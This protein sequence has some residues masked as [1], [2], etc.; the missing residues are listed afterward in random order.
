MKYFNLL[1]IAPTALALMLGISAKAQLV[2]CNGFLQGKYIEVGINSLGSYGSSTAAPAG[3]HPRGSSSVYNT[4]TGTSGPANSSLGFV[5]DPD[6]DG[7]GVGTPN[8]IGDYFLPGSPYEGWMIEVNGSKADANNGASSS[9]G[10][11]TSVTN[12]GATRSA[13]WVGAYAGLSIKQTTSFDTGNLFFTTKVVLKNTT[14]GTLTNVYYLRGVD[15]DQEQPVTGNFATNNTIAYQLPNTLNATLV[16][17]VGQTHGAYLGLGT[18]D[19]RAK[20]YILPSWPPSPALSSVYAGAS[21]FTYAGSNNGDYA[22]GIIFRLGNIVAGDSVTLIYTYI[23][24]G[25]DFLTALLATT[26]NWTASGDATL[27]HSTADTAKVCQSS[28]TTVTISNPGTSTW[29]WSALTGETLSATTGASVTVTTA[30]TIIKLRAVGVSTSSVDTM[31]MYLNPINTVPS[32]PTAGSNSP[33]CQNTALNLTA[34]SGGGTV[35][36]YSWSGPSGFS[37]TVQNPTISSATSGVAG[38]YMVYA[39]N[40]ACFSATGANTTVSVS[41]LAAI[42]GA[43]SLVVSNTTTLTDATGGGTWSSSNNAVATVTSGGLVT[44][45]AI[46]SV[47]ISY[48]HGSCTATKTIAII[49]VPYC[50]ALYSQASSAC[51]VYNMFIN[52]FSFTGAG[53]STLSDIGS[54]CDGT[55]YQDRRGIVGIP[56]VLPGGSY[57]TAIVVGTTYN[58]N[59][60]AWV[61]FNNNGTFETSESIGGASIIG[62]STFTI[63]IPSG[64]ALGTH[65]MRVRVGYSGSTPTYPGLNACSDYSYGEAQDYFIN[66]VSAC[67][68]PTIT[69]AG[70]ITQS[71]ATGACSATVSYSAATATGTTPTITYNHSSGTTFSVGVTTVTATATNSCGTANCSFTVTV[72]DTQAP[73]I[74][75]SYVSATNDAGTCGASVTLSAT[76]TDNCSVGTPSNDWTGGAFPVGTTTVNWTVTDI[77]GNTGTATQTVTV[78]DNQAPVISVTNVSATNDA[79]TCGAS[80]TLSATA[81]DN[82]SVG[83]PSNDWTGGAFPVGTTT[84][85]WTVTDIHGNTSTATQTVTVTDNENP[86]IAAPSSITANNTTGACGTTVSL[87]SPITADN[88]GVASVTNNHSSSTYPVGTTTVIWTVTDVHGHTATATQTVTVIDNEAPYAICQNYTLNLSGGTGSI[89]ATNINNG[90]YDNCGIASMSVYPNSF[91]CSNAGSNTVTLTVKD[92]HGNI[93]TCTATVTVRYQPTCS[94][95]VTKSDTTF[96]GGIVNNI[97]FGYGA[98]A[99]TFT[100]TASGGSGFTYSWYPSTYLSSASVA[101]PTFTPTV[102]G[103]YTYTLTATNSNGCSTTCTVSMCVVDAVDHSH[104]KKVILCHIPPG[105]PGNPNELSISISAVPAH[106]SGHTGDHLGACYSG[107]GIGAKQNKIAVADANLRVYPNP[108]NGSFSVVIPATESEAIVQVTDMTGRVLATRNIADNHGDAIEFNLTNLATGIYFVKVKAGAL[109]FVEKLTVR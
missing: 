38:V 101:N 57:T 103:H 68:V 98:Q 84:V 2:S 48:S 100:G 53:G 74:S 21:G 60:Q 96:T 81:T 102:A 94:I 15:P 70:N 12:S 29:T 33:V 13:L 30:T 90:S 108:T 23:L 80:V 14:S 86:T 1:K 19:T 27:S 67:T 37:T 89:S 44:G 8:Y 32:A 47:T 78:T 97:Y 5:A 71:A 77:H 24:R 59:A 82:C 54:G 79:G 109:S 73:V 85:N 64:A 16:T 91:N 35:T 56:N 9:L 104:S 52:S 36:S 28:P 42:A 51:S 92:V 39:V 41:P 75:V 87:G 66:V 95:A 26:S 11:I 34:T 18:L 83:T 49:G 46:G 4:C 20:C 45:V 3:Y 99:S 93:S 43:S 107:C 22:M 6:K 76:A 106:L 72:N 7:W 50:T 10:S 40:G 69:C 65:T 61:D 31:Y 105:N 55:G 63:T 17:A 25:S 58:E 88:C 62:T